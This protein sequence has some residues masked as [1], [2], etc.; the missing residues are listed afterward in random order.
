[1]IMV[2]L[3]LCVLTI[4]IVLYSAFAGKGK[5]VEE[6]KN[7]KDDYDSKKDTVIKCS[8]CGFESK[9][10]EFELLYYIE[11]KQSSQVLTKEVTGAQLFGAKSISW[12]NKCSKCGNVF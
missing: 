1:M 9:M 3:I 2:L 4:V 6:V 11:Y 7:V 5:R 12:K 10:K 8:K